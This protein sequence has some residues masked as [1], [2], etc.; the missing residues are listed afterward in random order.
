MEQYLSSSMKVMVLLGAYSS[1]ST[2]SA[3]ELRIR[4]LLPHWSLT[5]SPDSTISTWSLLVGLSNCQSPSMANEVLRV[6]AELFDAIREKLAS[7]KMSIGC[8]AHS[9]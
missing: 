5:N 6:G 7:K 2:D 4:E 9:P 1:Y 8:V 3:V